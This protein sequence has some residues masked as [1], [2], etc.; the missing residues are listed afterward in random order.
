MFKWLF[1]SKKCIA[2]KRLQDVTFHGR[3]D[4]MNTSNMGRNN[5]TMGRNG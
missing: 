2:L 4:P 5:R 1:S 3:Q